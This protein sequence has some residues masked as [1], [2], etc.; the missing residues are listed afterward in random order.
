M[1]CLPDKIIC[2]KKFTANQWHERGCNILPVQFCQ[3]LFSGCRREI[4]FKKVFI[5]SEPVSH[6]T[7]QNMVEDFMYLLSI[8]LGQNMFSGCSNVVNQ[9]LP[10][11]SKIGRK[12]IAP[13]SFSESFQGFQKIRKNDFKHFGGQCIHIC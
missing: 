13:L 1:K 7:A 3:N 5:K 2:S 4:E 8:N 11:S 12:P 6:I 10:K 9:S